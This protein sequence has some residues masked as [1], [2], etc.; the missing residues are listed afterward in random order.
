MGLDANHRVTPSTFFAPELDI[1]QER[2]AGDA[3]AT[4]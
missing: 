3:G 1:T 4:E 2:V